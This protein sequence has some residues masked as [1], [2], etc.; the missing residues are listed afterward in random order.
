M[1]LSIKERKIRIEK[2]RKQE[3]EDFL[4]NLNKKRKIDEDTYLAR[5]LTLEKEL[6]DKKALFEKDIAE[7][8]RNQTS[9]NHYL[10]Y[11]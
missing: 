8:H 5:K 1:E 7:R 9:K 10:Q 4:Y 11:S 2:E 6:S 3:E